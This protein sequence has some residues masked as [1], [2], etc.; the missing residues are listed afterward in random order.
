MRVHSG[1]RPFRCGQCSMK[2]SYKYVLNHHMEVHTNPRSRILNVKCSV[3]TQK[4]FDRSQ[5]DAHEIKCN[6]RRYECYLCQNYKTYMKSNLQFHMRM[7][8]TGERPF[9]CNFC[10]KCYADKS[11]FNRHIK[12][13]HKQQSNERN[14]CTRSTGYGHSIT[15][16]FLYSLIHLE[17]IKI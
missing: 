17:Q 6:R 13:P 3:C 5:K 7:Q 1:A 2:F 4:F 10:V 8:H 15:N 16:N 11:Q 12:R 9:K 14:R